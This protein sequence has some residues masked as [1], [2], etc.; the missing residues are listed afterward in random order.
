MFEQTF[1]NIGVV[2]IPEEFDEQVCSTGYFALRTKESVAHPF[3]EGNGRA[4]RIWLDLIL[5][6]KLKKLVNWQLIDKY[7]YL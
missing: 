6:C 5:K 3:M 7:L 4:M 1:K 2:L